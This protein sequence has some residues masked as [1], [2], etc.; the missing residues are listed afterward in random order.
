MIYYTT[1]KDIND[2]DYVTEMLE[3][4]D[5]PN[6]YWKELGRQLGIDDATLDEID[7]NGTL[8]ER[9]KKCMHTWLKGGDSDKQA[10]TWKT[11]VNALDRM[12]QKKVADKIKRDNFY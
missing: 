5:F 12:G 6:S 11:L 2:L 4:N 9:F 3:R 10:R 7:E 8:K 1:F